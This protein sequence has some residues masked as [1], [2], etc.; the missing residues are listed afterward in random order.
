MLFK[1]IYWLMYLDKHLGLFPS[2][3]KKDIWAYKICGF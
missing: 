1:F 2:K 3:K